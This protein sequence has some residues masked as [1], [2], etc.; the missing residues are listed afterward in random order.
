MKKLEISDKLITMEN[1][2][3]QQRL[4]YARKIHADL[5]QEELIN[6]VNELYDELGM[7]HA[8]QASYSKFESGKNLSFK[9]LAAV[10]RVT[11]VRMDWL[12]FGIQTRFPVTR[13]A[14]HIPLRVLSPDH[15]SRARPT[16]AV[17]WTSVRS[18][19]TAWACCSSTAATPS[20]QNSK[21][22]P[23]GSSTKTCG[24]CRP[25]SGCVTTRGQSFWTITSLC[26]RP[27][28]R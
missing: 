8:T 11:G 21:H 9:H 28:L 24:R 6:K 15:S 13:R 3:L 14:T 2:N 27:A 5:T 19:A 10:A 7:P 16:R 4:L 1:M 20:R 25:G 22:R 18:I 26:R 12:A 23:T 17:C